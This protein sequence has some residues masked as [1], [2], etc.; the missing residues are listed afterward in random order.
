MGQVFN[1][2]VLR[3]ILPSIYPSIHRSPSIQLRV[4]N[5]DGGSGGEGD[6]DD[7]DDDGDLTL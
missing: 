4:T 3:F 6:D 5:R 1:S 7:N 2:G